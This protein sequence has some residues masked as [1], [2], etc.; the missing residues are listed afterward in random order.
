M[1]GWALAMQGQS[2]EGMVQVRQGIAS[3]R[4]TGAALLVPYLCTMLA[5]VSTHPGHTEDGLGQAPGTTSDPA[6]PRHAGDGLQRS[7]VPRSRFQPRLM[8]GVR[9][10]WPLKGRK[11]AAHL[12]GVI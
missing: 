1:R 8:P 5:D 6:E 3:F 2:A 12:A 9:P 7:L 10:L 4:A 11:V